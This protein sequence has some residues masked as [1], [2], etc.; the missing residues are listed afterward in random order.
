MG[1]VDFS[2]DVGLADKSKS[3]SAADW[4]DLEQV[5]FDCRSFMSRTAGSLY[6]ETVFPT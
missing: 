2:R 6:F 5:Q 3:M 4:G 1:S